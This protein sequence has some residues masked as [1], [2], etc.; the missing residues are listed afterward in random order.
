[1]LL[2]LKIRKKINILLGRKADCVYQLS[3]YNNSWGVLSHCFIYSTHIHKQIKINLCQHTLNNGSFTNSRKVCQISKMLVKLCSVISNHCLSPQ[4][5]SNN[6]LTWVYL[7][8]W[9][10]VR[11]CRGIRGSM[12]PRII[13]SSQ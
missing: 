7:L 5:I 8:V 9:V 6:V 4:K 1:M 3:I 2:T 12:I 10:I 13:W 11:I